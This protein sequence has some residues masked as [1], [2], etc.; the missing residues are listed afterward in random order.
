MRYLYIELV[1]YAG[2][3]NGLGLNQIKIDFTKCK[4][5]KI[6]IRGRNGSGKSTLMNAINPNPDGNENFIPNVEARKTMSLLH[7]GIEY[8]IRYV[9][10]ITTTGNRSTTKGY[11]SKNINGQMVELN[12]NGNI[13]SCRNIMYEEFN[14]DSNY[15]SL[16]KLSSENRGLVDNKPAERKKLINSIINT[17]DAYNGI[18]KNLSKKSSTYK[19]LINSIVTKVDYIGDENLIS[20]QLKQIESRIAALEEDRSNGIE[21][22]AAIKVKISEMEQFLIDNNYN[23]IISDLRIISKDINSIEN[24]LN[25]IILKYSIKS[26]DYM[27][28][29]YNQLNNDINKLDAEIIA[30]KEIIPSLL[31]QRET[32]F[33]DLQNK[34][35]RLKS[36]QSEYN[37]IDIKNAMNKARS[38]VNEYESVFQSMGIKDI[39]LITKDEFDSAM[40]S[41][42]YLINQASII[43][44]SYSNEDINYVL[45]H[46]NEMNSI[47]MSINE[48]K[49]NIDA[50]INMKQELD[51][52]IIIYKSKREVAKELINRPKKCKIDNC[53]YIKNA[54]EAENNYPD[55]V[56]QEKLI[57]LE[58][59]NRDID[60]YKIRIEKFN[61]VIEIYNRFI[62]IKKELKSHI[63]FIKKLPVSNDFE[64]SFLYRIA[65]NDPFNEIKD[66]YK[67][68]DYGNILEEFKLAKKQLHEYELEYKIYESKNEIIEDLINSIN[69]LNSKVDEIVIKIGSINKEISNKEIKLQNLK[70]IKDDI[71]VAL[72]K[73]NEQLIPSKEKQKELISLK[74]E[75]DKSTSKLDEYKNNLNIANSNLGSINSDI[76]NLSN[77]RDKLKHSLELLKDYKK[78]LSIYNEKY[79]KIEKIRYYSSPSTGIQTLFMQIYM[80][81]II[82]T[83]NELLSLLFDGEFV[84]QPFIINENE[85]RIPCLGNGLIH[86]D[87]SSM[88]TAQKCMISMIL[89][90]ALLHQSSTKYN[91]L[92]LDEIDGGL[93]TGNRG[94]FIDLL[95]R[96]MMMLQCE[97][98]FIVSHNSELSTSMADIILLKT[99]PNEIYSGNIIWK[100]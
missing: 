41:L 50:L 97:Q 67:Y 87:I 52:E 8:I 13:S 19:S 63:K 24:A 100:F 48:I 29:Y 70:L 45:A 1:G 40:E 66:L 43:T 3:Y 93:D 72:K 2:I 55:K 69:I 12:P 25:N 95:D 15:I 94:Y 53:P 89:S 20:G 17:L 7:N 71:L 14:L 26:I 73:I 84:L 39:D 36:L 6:I 33:N 46:W 51:K 49:K 30:Q 78:E 10:P 47:S 54:I 75:L 44:A 11:I 76:K 91:I 37:Y 56:L 90:F 34:Q 35:E 98:C 59:Y 21:I 4:F 18:Y 96:L 57:L 61:I 92:F 60:E 64:E 88:S 85:F 22:T 99:D 38:T 86:D 31:A 79:I 83:A 5:N 77:E 65:N 74:E 27:E 32:E 23:N 9:H 68:I 28:D 16:S 81:K 42:G 80:N 82:T 62:D 58:S